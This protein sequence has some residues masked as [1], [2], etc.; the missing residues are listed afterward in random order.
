M[1]VYIQR[2]QAH[3]A[4]LR[5]EDPSDPK[6]ED[7]EPKSEETEPKPEEA[8]PKPE[9]ELQM[10]GLPLQS[11]NEHSS[12]GIE[13]DLPPPT[14]GTAMSS[15]LSSPP[16]PVV[17]LNDTPVPP[18]ASDPIPSPTPPAPAPPPPP[19]NP[20]FSPTAPLHKLISRIAFLS[21]SSLS[22]ADERLNASE[23]LLHLFDRHL[24]ILDQAIKDTEASLALGTR[25]G[26]HPNA[27]VLP[28]VV[29]PSARP[30]KTV[31]A[32]TATEEERAVPEK[33]SLKIRVPGAG[34]VAAANTAGA[35]DEERFCYCNQPSY[36]DV[37]SPFLI[38]PLP[39]SQ[40]SVLPLSPPLS[41]RGKMSLMVSYRWLCAIM[42]N[43]HARGSISDV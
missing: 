6:P 42:G 24:S 11:P 4:Q 33:I 19:V 29:A 27:L 40:N 12:N 39:Y 13:V 31:K 1:Q 36:G 10:D 14:N 8:E 37:S 22:S 16:S 30:Q 28:A 23:S 7:S 9:T 43:V 41:S 34:A 32:V 5:Q 35:T 25:K 18:T 26:T 17:A 15:P 20:L 38:F 3:A 2:R 21:S